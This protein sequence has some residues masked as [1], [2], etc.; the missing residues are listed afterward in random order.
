MQ[1][2]RTHDRHPAAPSQTYDDLSTQFPPENMGKGLLLSEIGDDAL[3]CVVE[4][5][6]GRSDMYFT[7]PEAVPARNDFVIVEADRGH[8]LGKVTL[9][10]ISR[11][12]LIAMIKQQENGEENS[13]GKKNDVYVKRVL[14]RATSAEVA[15]L[16][17]KNQDEAKALLVCQSKI[18]QKQMPMQVVD[19]EYQWDKRKLTFY[20]VA[21]RRVDFRELVRDLFK[22]YKTRI[23]M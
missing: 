9:E 13:I 16:V 21:D 7:T 23:W 18:K 11:A 5:K 20:F 15:V 17:S 4:F 10:R 6:R 1:A 8:D 12:Q 14:R 2:L 19:A 3:F 22:L